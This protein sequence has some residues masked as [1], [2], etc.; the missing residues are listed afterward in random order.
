MFGVLI[1][2]HEA[3][4]FAAAKLLGVK[5]NEFSIGMGPQLLSR[6]KGETEYSLRAIPIGGYCAMEGEDEGTG[7]PGSFSEKPA[8]IKFII[9]V[10]GA[11]MNLLIGVL[12]LLILF[13]QSKTFITPVISEFMDGF[14]Y[15]SQEELMLGDRIVSVNGH[16]VNVY[17]DLNLYFV[18][19]NGETVTLGI[20]R[21]GAYLERRFPLVQREY[22]LDGETQL[23]YGF[24][25]TEETATPAL[26]LHET[27]GTTL[28]FARSVWFGLQAIVTRSLSL[29]DLSGP[30]GIIS[31]IGQAGAESSN[32]ATGLWS[33]F[34]LLSLI[35]VNLAIMNLLPLP[36][37][38]G[39]RILFLAVDGVVWLLT[40]KKLNPKYEG[41]V[42]MIGFVLLLGLMVIVT[43][44]DIAKLVT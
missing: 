35:A 16:K 32:A 44:N 8:W 20:Q 22:V 4:H 40:R 18:K 43:L 37:L 41:Y 10:A 11:A 3:G 27:W 19:Y 2:V 39:G 36:A 23:K 26:V 28:Y 9:L 24:I 30:V 7:D 42:H 33:V 12:I 14:P 31:V 6:K 25:F 17:Y 34:F 1:A 38:D 13:S 21:N 5:V 15:E 29:S